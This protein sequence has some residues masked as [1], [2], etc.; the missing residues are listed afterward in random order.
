V[1]ARATTADSSGAVISEPA[2]G[3][4]ACARPGTAADGRGQGGGADGAAPAP[5]LAPAAAGM[6]GGRSGEFTGPSGPADAARLPASWQ[7]ASGPATQTRSR[8]CTIPG[9][10]HLTLAAI[11]AAVAAATAAQAGAP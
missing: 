5:N 1:I 7:L 2:D 3:S 11:E 4:A 9:N 6:D 8:T 10:L